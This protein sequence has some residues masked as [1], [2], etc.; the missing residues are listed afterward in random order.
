MGLPM[1]E[2]LTDTG[3]DKIAALH[4]LS[5]FE[6]RPAPLDMPRQVLERAPAPSLADW[7]GRLFM[8]NA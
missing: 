2:R 4:D 8:R 3:R 1:A 5:R 7:I 6:P